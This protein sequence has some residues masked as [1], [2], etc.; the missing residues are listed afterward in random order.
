[1]IEIFI[2]LIQLNGYLLVLTY[3]NIILAETKLFIMLMN[4]RNY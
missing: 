4:S 2:S 1:M 3:G